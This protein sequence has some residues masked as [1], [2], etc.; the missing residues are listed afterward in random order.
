MQIFFFC[1]F[2][3]FFFIFLYIKK[4]ANIIFLKKLG[5]MQFKT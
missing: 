5:R 2:Y 4:N 1:F 3:I